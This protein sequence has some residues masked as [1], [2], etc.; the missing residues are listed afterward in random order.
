MP[1]STKETPRGLKEAAAGLVY[2]SEIDAPFE[3]ISLGM[4]VAIPDIPAILALAGEKNTASREIELDRFFSGHIEESDPA[5]QVAREN[6]P[7][8]E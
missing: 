3:F 8:F 2:V 1:G 4:H 6:V 7:R 5:D